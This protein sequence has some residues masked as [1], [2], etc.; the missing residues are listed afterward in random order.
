MFCIP[1]NLIVESP[2]A[3]FVERSKPEPFIEAVQR[4]I[5]Y[6]RQREVFREI[7]RKD[8]EERER[9]KL[10]DELRRGSRKIFNGL[11]VDEVE[12]W[13]FRAKILRERA[14]IF[15]IADVEIFR[16]LI[17]S[18]RCQ[19]LKDFICERTSGLRENRTSRDVIEFVEKWF[20]VRF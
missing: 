10:F 3:E 11:D 19:H 7:D 4:E 9:H 2:Q 15:D 8:A 13:L 6:H 16:S 5:R 20:R 12:S 18:I 14:K 17:F 1:D